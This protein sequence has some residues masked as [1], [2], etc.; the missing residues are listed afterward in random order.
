MFEINKKIGIYIHF[1]WCVRKCPYCVFN[2]HPIKDD[3][4]LSEQYY[5][6][7]IA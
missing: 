1:P 6:K 5:H 3:S 2:S 4:Y 7:L